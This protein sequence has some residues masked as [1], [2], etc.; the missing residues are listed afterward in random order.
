MDQEDRDRLIKIEVNV[1]WLKAGWIEHL[2]SHKTLR[3]LVYGAIIAA[4]V[5]LLF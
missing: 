3:Y 4:A 5:G 2:K 1:D